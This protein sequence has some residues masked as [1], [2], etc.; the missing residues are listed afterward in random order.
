MSKLGRRKLVAISAIILVT[1]IALILP[2]WV[3]PWAPVFHVVCRN[4][5]SIVTNKQLWAPVVLANSPYGGKTYDNGTIPPSI[6]SSPGY[7]DAW[8]ALGAPALNG[9]ADAALLLTNIDLFSVQN[10]TVPGPGANTPCQA[11][12]DLQF[13]PLAGG[14]GSGSQASNISIPSVF[15]DEGEAT[16]ASPGAPSFV[17]QNGF[18]S[19]NSPAVSTCH[20]PGQTHIAYA[21]D[22]KAWV[23]SGV[24]NSAKLTPVT[25]PFAVHFRYVFPPNFGTWQIDNLSA[26]GGPGGGWAFSYTPCAP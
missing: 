8:A 4:Q 19:A 21:P 16:N 6:P 9:S 24:G 15:S 11:S 22:F 3:A 20:G 25:L 12:S 13:L 5:S 1:S 2:T 23:P 14:G 17:F 26:P 18:S 10:E 7:P